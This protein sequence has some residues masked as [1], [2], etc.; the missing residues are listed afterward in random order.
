MGSV[1]RIMCAATCVPEGG[2]RDTERTRCAIAKLL[3]MK[4]RNPK[5]TSGGRS[6]LPRLAVLLAVYACV[7]I[8]FVGVFYWISPEHVASAIGPVAGGLIGLLILSRPPVRWWMET[9]R[10]R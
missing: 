9:L 5:P 7:A 4:A 10:R 2:R 6:L 8:A 1:L 3:I